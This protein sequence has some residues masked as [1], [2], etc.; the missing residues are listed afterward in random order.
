MEKQTRFI[1]FRTSNGLAD[2][3]QRITKQERTSLYNDSYAE[4]DL[5]PPGYSVCIEVVFTNSRIYEK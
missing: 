1:G 5:L 4:K 2:I 3:R